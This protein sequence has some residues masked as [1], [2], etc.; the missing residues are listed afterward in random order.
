MPIIK[1]AE[2]LRPLQD[3]VGISPTASPSVLD[4]GNV[5][6]TGPIFPDITR[7]GRST[8]SDGWGHGVITTVHSIAS[9]VF[10][11][12][13]PYDQAAGNV[14]PFPAPVERFLDLWLLGICGTRFS[15]AGGLTAAI[16]ELFPGANNQQFFGVDDMGAAVVQNRALPLVKWVAL[17]GEVNTTDNA[18]LDASGNCYVPFNMRLPRNCT[19]RST[20]VSSDEA[21]FDMK[22]ILGLFAGGL[23]QDIAT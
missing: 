18:M 4:D 13:T 19:I 7:R 1:L 17:D 6:L 10:T 9:T 14:L 12:V 23:G 16:V 5:A 20:T 2:I 8:G 21:T 15:G 11:D 22:L 3:L